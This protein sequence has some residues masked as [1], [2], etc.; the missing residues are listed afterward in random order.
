MRSLGNGTN[1]STDRHQTEFGSQIVMKKLKRKL[2]NKS[3][4]EAGYGPNVN[5]IIL[6]LDALN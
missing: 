6:I 5:Y 3:K 1:T 4:I 2:W